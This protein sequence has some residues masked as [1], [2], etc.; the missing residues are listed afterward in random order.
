MQL[1]TLSELGPS[2]SAM[3]LQLALRSLHEYCVM[4]YDSSAVYG[5]GCHG[6]G[7]RCIVRALLGGGQGEVWKC[8]DSTRATRMT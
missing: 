3:Q 6:G 5:A 4:C 8:S 2:R 7:L 1:L